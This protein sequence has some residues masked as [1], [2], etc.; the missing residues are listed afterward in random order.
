MACHLVAKRAEK[1]CPVG[2]FLVAATRTS[3]A[4]GE[5]RGGLGAAGGKHANADCGAWHT[6]LMLVLHGPGCHP[7]A[8]GLMPR[9]YMLVL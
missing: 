7:P 3:A 8:A 1:A 9:A 5:P 2:G 6:K 4:L